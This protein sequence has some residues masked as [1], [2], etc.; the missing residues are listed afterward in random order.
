MNTVHGDDGWSAWLEATQTLLGEP[1]HRVGNL[2]VHIADPTRWDQDQ[3]SAVDGALVATGSRVEDVARTI[4]PK[5]VLSA[6]DWRARAEALHARWPVRT[7]FKRM[8]D[9]DGRGTNQLARTIDAFKAGGVDPDPITFIRPDVSAAA[10]QSFPCL[11]QVQFHVDRPTRRLQMTA[12]YRSQYYDTKA[13]GNFIG[14]SRIMTLV[15]R[16]VGVHSGEM[17]VIAT[18]ARLGGNVRALR[19]FIRN[20]ASG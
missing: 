9:F 17:L 1:S 20:V 5:T 15:S 4:L 18:D 10:H 8:I 11:S 12:T 2:I 13:L 3:I 7:Y 14:L 6:T 16:E 19:E